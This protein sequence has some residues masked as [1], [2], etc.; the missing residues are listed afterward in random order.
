MLNEQRVK[1]MTKMTSYEEGEGKRNMEIGS[2]FRGDYIGK[3]VVKSIVFGT[4]AFVVVFAIYI[5]Y[6]YEMYMQDIYK[7]DLLG[8]GKSVA[9]KY[10]IFIAVYAAITYVVYALRYKIARRSLRI[11]YNNLR[12]LSAMYRKEAEEKDDE[13]NN[14]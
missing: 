13:R 1:L 3:E 4:M 5:A 9:T 2:Y 10:L 12:R 11:Y 14:G 6:D 8:F 7:M